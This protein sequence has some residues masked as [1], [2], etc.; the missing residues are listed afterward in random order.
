MKR[1]LFALA[2]L[3]AGLTGAAGAQ[4]PALTTIRI[5]MPPT[6]AASQ[7]YYAQQKGFF[8]KVGLDAQILTINE[9]ASVAA[10]V[11]GGTADIGQANL[12]S[13][14]TAHERGLPFVAIAGSNLYVSSTHQ[15]ELV[16]AANA[17]Y[18]TARDLDGKTIAVAG[19][20]NVQAVS[21]NKWMDANG[22][23]WKSTKIVEV[24]F[25]EDEAAIETGRVDAAM[26][27]EPQL[28]G[29]LQ[30]KKVRIL[31][32]PM[33]AI[34]KQWIIGTWFTTAAYAKAHPAVIKA[35]AQAMAAS[36]DWANH[37]QAESGKLLEQQT[38]VMLGANASR[39]IFADRLEAR[40]MQPLIDASAKYGALKSSFPASELLVSE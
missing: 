29:A 16:V 1:A 40:D 2:L 28:S 13:L 5:A 23:N 7:G 21:F 36:A 17:P 35:F 27:A 20:Q 22:G 39:V 8:K 18:H 30:S 11:A 4:Q 9:G 31:S 26:M 15:S 37:N 3:T 12:S 14:C 6:D 25:A 32:T 19:L 10:A 34:G 33:D 24:P 38:G